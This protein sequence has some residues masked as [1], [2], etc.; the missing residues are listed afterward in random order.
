MWCMRAA[1]D[2]PVPRTRRRSPRSINGVPRNGVRSTY[3]RRESRNRTFKG[4]RANTTFYFAIQ[5]DINRNAFI[6]FCGSGAIEYVMRTRPDAHE[7]DAA[8]TLQGS[9]A[10]KAGESAPPTDRRGGDSGP[11]RNG[12]D[13][14]HVL[15]ICPAARRGN[16]GTWAFSMKFFPHRE[17]V[18]LQRKEFEGGME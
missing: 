18:A 1:T 3:T 12:T 10:V 8:G 13:C 5:T 11:R 4:H 17:T 7:R 9:A 16:A 6:A 2:C 14:A 15:G